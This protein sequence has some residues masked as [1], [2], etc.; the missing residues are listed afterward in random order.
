MMRNTRFGW[1][2]FVG[3]VGCGT[4]P[5]APSATAGDAAVLQ[6]AEAAA[7]PRLISILAQRSLKR[8]TGEDYSGTA[9]DPLS[10]LLT[11]TGR[12][13][14]ERAQILGVPV[15]QALSLAQD[16]ELRKRL[17]EVARWSDRPEAR[18]EGL[19]AL[20]SERNPAHYKFFREALLDKNLDIQLAAVE[21][22]TIWAGPEARPFLLQTAESNWSPLIRVLSAEAAWSLG[23]PQG[24][25]RVT[26]FL[27][28]PN[29][30]TRA[31]AFRAFGERGE[32]TDAEMIIARIAR[33]QDHRFVLAEACIAGL[34]LLAKKGPGPAVPPPAL[35]P[36]PR[37]AKRPLPSE[38]FEMEALVVTAPRLRISGAQLVDPR[39]DNQLVN[40]LEKLANETAP[41][42]QVDDPVLAE[43][44]RFFTPTGIALKHRYTN[45]EYL[46]TEGLA[47][48]S[49]YTLVRRLEEIARNGRGDLAK[50]AALVAL[51]Y[52]PTRRDLF[53][54]QEFLRADRNVALRFA[55]VEAL[56]ASGKP[57][58]RSLLSSVAQ[59]DAADFLRVYAAYALH[60]TGDDYGLVILQRYLTDPDWVVR[61]MA[62]YLLGASGGPEDVDR[63]IANMNAESR[64]AVTAELCLAVLRLAQ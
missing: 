4:V 17:V 1:L 58:A 36:P 33:E 63:L 50:A 22:L 48:T 64:D 37:A 11:P 26:G 52:D 41:D 42:V 8:I 49:N 46:L 15:A 5:L 9:L 28:D 56:L 32:A 12:R 14:F 43:L 35:P 39:I 55:A 16:P 53:L 44:N 40:L 19:V 23:D 61:A 18:A 2:L 6:R 20:A 31:L 51:G 60:R 10:R 38:L 34:K 29:W 27:S 47:G 57:E 25:A 62:S 30:L 7:S 54:F 45:I 13:L 21:A 3:A 59:G 24:R